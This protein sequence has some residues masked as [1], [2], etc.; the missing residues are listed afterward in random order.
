MADNKSHDKPDENSPRKPR[1]YDREERITLQKIVTNIPV[2]RKMLS[3]ELLVQAVVKFI[4]K[5]IRIGSTAADT[6]NSA[7]VPQLFFPALRSVKDTTEA[8]VK[9][10]P[11]WYFE[12]RKPSEQLTEINENEVYIVGAFLE[13]SFDDMVSRLE[14]KHSAK[15]K[16][17]IFDEY[18]STLMSYSDMINDENQEHFRELCEECPALGIGKQSTSED[19]K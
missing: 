11:Y 14:K 9:L 13:R 2:T 16:Q 19:E 7:L 5:N 17:K 1:D 4:G 3:Q 15:A 12:G 18:Q 10:E 8:L 6:V